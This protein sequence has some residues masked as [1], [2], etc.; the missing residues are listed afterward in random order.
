MTTLM[1]LATR[2]LSVLSIFAMIS[3]PAAAQGVS[4]SDMAFAF[5][6]KAIAP[7]GTQQTTR[8]A[9]PKAAESVVIASARGMTQTEMRETEGA[10]I[11]P[12]IQIGRAVITG[13]TRHGLN[14]AIDR[15]IS[16]GAIVNTLR[17]PTSVKTFTTGA[18]AG[19]TRYIGPQSTVVVNNQ[20]RVV[21]TWGRGR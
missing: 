3:L 13:F 8:G 19:T 4:A 16:P 14:Q 6:G 17:N 7:A 5:G 2:M 12:A 21:T 15:G 20:G 11:G 10:W 9:A 18:N 1:K